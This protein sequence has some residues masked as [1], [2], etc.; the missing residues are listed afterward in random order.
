MDKF[1]LYNFLRLSKHG[2]KHYHGSLVNKQKAYFRV[3]NLLITAWSYI[4][5]ISS[6]CQR[7]KTFFV[8]NKGAK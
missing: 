1:R 2:L 6:K 4:Y 3:F 8:N 7:F 5:E